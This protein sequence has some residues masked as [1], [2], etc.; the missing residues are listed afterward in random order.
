MKSVSI[1]ALLTLILTASSVAHADAETENFVAYL[2]DATSPHVAAICEE[3]FPGF[4]GDFNQVFPEWQTAYAEQVVAGMLQAEV[5]AEKRGQSLSEYSAE[6]IN[7]F[8]N[9]TLQ[10]AS[11]EKE[12]YCTL[13]LMKLM[14]RPRQ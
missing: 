5:A 10:L 3:S 9:K 11:K 7:E 13:M 12:R 6:L 14:L 1:Y 2:Q 8:K 4:I